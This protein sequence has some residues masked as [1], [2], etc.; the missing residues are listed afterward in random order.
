MESHI[1]GITDTEPERWKRLS[2]DVRRNLLLALAS[3]KALP[4]LKKQKVPKKRRNP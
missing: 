3:V 1:V 2:A 4:F